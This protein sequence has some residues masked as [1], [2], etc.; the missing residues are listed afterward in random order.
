MLVTTNRLCYF[1]DHS[2]IYCA[3]HDRI[4]NELVHRPFACNVPD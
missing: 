3:S 2:M 1:C 4:N